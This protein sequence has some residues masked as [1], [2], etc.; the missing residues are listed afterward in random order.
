MKN[1]IKTILSLLTIIAFVILNWATSQDEEIR[2]VQAD[3]QIYQD[4][5]LILQNQETDLDF[6]DAYLSLILAQD[7]LNYHYNLD[8]YHLEAMTSD[9]IEMIEF[10]YA[11]DGTGTPYPDS[12]MPNSFQLSF[13]IESNVFGHYDKDF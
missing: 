2:V 8:A 10:I 5:L 9:T 6:T 4:T 12:L 7:S 3:V 11:L 1:S 13:S